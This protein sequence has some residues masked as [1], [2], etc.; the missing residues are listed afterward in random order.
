MKPDSKCALVTGGP[1][2]IGPAIAGK[3]SAQ[4]AWV[5]VLASTEAAKA[6]SVVADIEAAGGAVTSPPPMCDPILKPGATVVS[7][8]SGGAGYGAPIGRAAEQVMEDERE[9]TVSRD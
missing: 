6:Q 9:G 8:S 7:Y 4:G 1:S 3:F 2:G 5:A